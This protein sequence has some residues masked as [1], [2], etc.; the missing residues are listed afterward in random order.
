V[1]G[2]VGQIH[3]VLLNLCVNARDA[4]PRGGVLHLSARN[5]S[6][7]EVVIE[8]GDTGTGIPPSVLDKIF[9]TFFT[10]K[11]PNKGTGLGLSTVMGIVKSHGGR[12][13]VE[14]TVGEGTCFRIWL[15]AHVDSAGSKEAKVV[16][17]P[18]GNGELILVVDDEPDMRRVTAQT[19]LQHGY[20]VVTAA[21]ASEAILQLTARSGE[22]PVVVTDLMMP[23][24]D[25]T[26]L[27]KSIRKLKPET[28][29]IATT[30]LSEEH[31][32]PEAVALLQKPYSAEDLLR[33]IFEALHG[34]AALQS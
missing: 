21:E 27:A 25:G 5:A 19:L 31:N 23:G 17:I 1:T 12:I 26:L 29:I 32:I 3:Q 28:K 18:Q 7:P 9:D 13:A 22:I 30:G 20:E 4:M 10:T 33:T 24:V 2:D 15:P 11:E 34:K 16:A 8:V 6:E 14:S